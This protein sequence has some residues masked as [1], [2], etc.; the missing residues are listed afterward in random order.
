MTNQFSIFK[1][2]I[3]RSINKSTSQLCSRLGNYYFYQRKIKIKF[4]IDS[5]LFAIG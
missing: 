5:T 3:S 4:S 1:I 2:I